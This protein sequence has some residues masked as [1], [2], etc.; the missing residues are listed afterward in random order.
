MPRH[1]SKSGNS[2]E[3]TARE[4]RAIRE[5]KESLWAATRR[6]LMDRRTQIII[7]LLLLA[8]AVLAAIAYVSYLFTG[9]A[10]QSILGMDRA[11]RISNR[12][13]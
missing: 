13:Q 11:D 9:T 4:E 1:S 2:L 8:F 5:E 10:D 3:D 7:G 12:V 6:V